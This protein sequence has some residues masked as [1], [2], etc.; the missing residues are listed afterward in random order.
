MRDRL[1]GE[2]D[3]IEHAIETLSDSRQRTVLRLRYLDG[4][5]W[6]EVAE[7]MCY[8]LQWV[9]KLHRKA[10]EQLRKEDEGK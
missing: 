5:K 4:L 10:L 6:E 7:R 9:F 2:R 8:C 3:A 1:I